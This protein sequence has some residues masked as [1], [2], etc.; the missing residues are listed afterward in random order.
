MSEST[1]ALASVRIAT[2]ITYQNMCPMND[3]PGFVRKDGLDLLVPQTLDEQIGQQDESQ[4][5]EHPHDC[6]VPHRVIGPPDQNL[7]VAQP[8][9]CGDGFEPLAQR[10]GG[11][12]SGVEN[13]HAESTARK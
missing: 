8:G 10:A 6:G 1:P 11:E 7:A 5:R 3:V 2:R 12:A 4:S 9:A 13:V